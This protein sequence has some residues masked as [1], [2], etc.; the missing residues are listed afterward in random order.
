MDATSWMSVDLVDGENARWGKYC[1]VGPGIFFREGGKR[2]RR[3]SAPAPANRGGGRCR[4]PLVK[5]CATPATS[6]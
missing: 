5:P 1:R 3:V 2:G 6:A 4:L